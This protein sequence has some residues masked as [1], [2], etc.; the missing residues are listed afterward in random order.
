MSMKKLIAG[1]AAASLAVTSLAA[2][3]VSAADES[4]VFD[5]TTEKNTI[6]FNFEQTVT[7]VQAALVANVFGSQAGKVEI[8]YDFQDYGT[9]SA[10]YTIPASLVA[11]MNTLFGTGV[12]TPNPETTVTVTGTNNNDEALTVSATTTTDNGAVDPYIALRFTASETLNGDGEAVGATLKD[13]HLDLTDFKTVKSVTFKS[14]ITMETGA[15]K[16]N[17]DAIFF[18]LKPVFT[19]SGPNI[20][21]TPV[22][23]GLGEWDLAKWWVDYTVK[24]ETDGSKRPIINKGDIYAFEGNGSDFTLID[25]AN[26]AQVGATT[27]TAHSIGYNLLRWTND[28]IILN[29]GAKLRLY[30]MTPAQAQAA[31]S[32]GQVQ[33]YPTQPSAGN[34]LEPGAITSSSTATY[35]IMMGVN[36]ANTTKLQKA[37]NIVDYVAEFDWDELV[38]A[39]TYTTS[40]NVDS[41]A[42]RVNGASPNVTNTFGAGPLVLDKIEI[43]I[44]D[45]TNIP[46]GYVDPDER[47]ISVTAGS[48]D[49]IVKVTGPFSAIY[50]KGDDVKVDNQITSDKLSY[51]CYVYNNGELS[52]LSGEVTLQL[53]VPSRVAS[54]LTE[55]KHT[56]NDGGSEM[57]AIQNASTYKTDGYII[58]KTSKFSG[59]E[60]PLEPE[61]SEETTTPEP[62]A[63]PTTE[64]ENEPSNGDTN[65]GANEPDKNAPTGVVLFAVP[66]I[67]AA[68]GVIVFKKRK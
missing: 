2:V 6:T 39:S 52:N 11:D 54:G 24:S 34:V 18:A 44:P 60:I 27:V 36:L 59:F 51:H 7:Y 61:E 37:V 45:Q 43:V 21:S 16:I 58:V 3:N 64:P 38:Q 41:I 10:S 66:A 26:G 63:D 57:L 29:K 4:I 9:K 46:G 23:L 68:A 20:G 53:S 35:D 30:F 5:F 56:F 31:V 33:A 19:T 28:H 50:G 14:T 15:L 13:G 48:G 32:K 55:I 8:G 42:F 49:Y 67:A 25:N 12:R 40:G 47:V 65:G 1:I 22:A 17:P 62:E